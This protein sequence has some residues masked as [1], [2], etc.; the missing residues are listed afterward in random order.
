[1]ICCLDHKFQIILD[2]VAELRR[3]DRV[4]STAFPD[5]FEIVRERAEPDMAGLIRIVIGQQISNS[6][7]QS[8]WQKMKTALNPND[9][10][11]ILNASDDHLKSFGLSRQ[12]IT[13]VKG[14]AQAVVNRDIEIDSWLSQP[15]DDTA[16]AITS[17]KG[18]GPWSAQMF[19]MFNLCERDIWPAGDLGLQMGLQRYFN[20]SERPSEKHSK[21][22]HNHFTGRGTAAAFLLWALKSDEGKIAIIN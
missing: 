15:P 19:L 10:Q 14:L 1:M 7:A 4:F 17:L 9:P 18:F 20:I 11:A 3:N 6:V 16:K 8:L 13:Y 5:G 22:Y 21:D 12:K 2:D